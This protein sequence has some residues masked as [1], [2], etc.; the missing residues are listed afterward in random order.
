MDSAVPSW[1]RS[2]LAFLLG[3]AMGASAWVLAPQISGSATAWDGGVRY[4]AVLVVAGG[5]LGLVD[6]LGVWPGVAGLYV[7]QALALLLHG[8]PPP[9]DPRNPQPLG[10]QLLFLVSITLAAMA[11]AAATATLAAWR[12]GRRA[13]APGAPPASP[14]GNPSAM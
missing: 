12:R 1:W 13:D 8:S 10:A 14:P 7:G 5:V 3:A 2:A 4:M 9:S 11:G 6:S